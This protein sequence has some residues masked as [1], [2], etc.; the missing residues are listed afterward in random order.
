MA[1]IRYVVHFPFEEI[2]N[3]SFY[4]YQTVLKSALKFK[5]AEYGLQ[6]YFLFIMSFILKNGTKIK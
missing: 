3:I 4:E 2:K 5:K 1:F 6:D